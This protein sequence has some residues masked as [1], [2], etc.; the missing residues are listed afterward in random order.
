MLKN[1]L[2]ISFRNLKKSL[3]V[4]LINILGLAIGISCCL[5][6]VLYVSDELSYDKHWKNAD[7]I[8]RIT[9]HSNIGT[10]ETATARTPS[11]L[12]RTIVDEYPEILHATRL[13]HTP[14]MLVRYKD[15]VYNEDNF[16]WVDTNFF[17]V[18]PL[19][20]LYGDPKTA[21]K[22]DHTVVFTLDNAK[23]Y[24]RNPA[25]ALNKIVEFEDGTPYRVSAVVANPEEN[26]HFH[27]G[28][29]SPLSSWE[30]NWNEWWLWNF[31]C[32]YVLLHEEAD[33]QELEAKLPR[34]LQ[35]YAAPHFKETTGMT[36]DEMEK[37]G[38]KY[39]YKLQPITSIHLHSH[40]DGELEP[41]SD[42]KYIYIFS[43]TAVF[44]LFVAC[45][46]FMNLATSRSTGRARE[47]GMRKV[48]GS[49]KKR[50]IGQFLVESILTCIPAVI[51]AM[52]LSAILLPL[53]N[54]IANKEIV[55]N[56]LKP[57]YMLP[58]LGIFT[59]ILGVLA[60]SYPAFFLSSFQPVKVLKENLGLG[61]KGR[62][63][64]QIL[65]IFQ[66]TISIIL[67]ITTLLL[68]RQMHFIQNKRLGFNK[69]NIVVI[70]RGWALGQNPDG[71]F[72]DTTYQQSV[73][74]SF[75]NDLK[76]NPQIIS[77]CGT[78]N[79]PGE[80]LNNAVL[81]TKGSA[82]QEQHVIN[83]CRVDWDYAETFGIEMLEG[84]F[85]SREF[86]NWHGVI[87]NETAAKVFGLKQPYTEQYL[88]FP[89]DSSETIPIFGVVK[90]FHYE[91][92]HQPI[93]PLVIDFMTEGR[94]YIC[95]R[96]RPENVRETVNYIKP[97]WD[98]YIPYKPFEYFFFDDNYNNLYRAEIRTN[99]LFSIFS[100]LSI[101]IA[102]LGLFALAS[103]TT[104]RRIREIGIRK[105]LGATVPDILIL[106]TKEFA[107][108]VAIANLAAWPLA[109]YIM[110]RT[111]QSYAYRISIGP[112]PFLMAG[113]AALIIALITV[114]YH[115]IKAALSNPADTL[116]YE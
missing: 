100:I 75:K 49:T 44:I 89:G 93:K 19:K 79:L 91:S 74:E 17:D 110:R 28:M 36:F 67:F 47:V 81:T 109:Y 7:R 82:N 69:E 26:A 37:A 78:S 6:I 105:T 24:F 60:G 25:E 95:V 45:I 51:I 111:L 99:K 22:D 57:W 72:I 9:V 8:Y 85:Y 30:W 116:K 46:N 106:L 96:I 50:L 64:R 114:S 80:G 21:L 12:S 48:L 4:N 15:L 104:E 113:L 92:L 23:K 53:F 11:Q 41:N 84:R 101:I 94:T 34:F 83:H 27:Y 76:Q 88:G 55:I 5:L 31:M 73:F 52:I 63:F 58:V 66:F 71:S 38:G 98:K 115:S 107:L 16:L 29:L 3:G 13:E 56:Y 86:N 2:L 112:G 70:K 108:L 43:V 40:L 20:I 59:I 14:N 33:P 61:T 103:F 62:G 42:I 97:I 39:E 1:Y 68:I 35:K 65:V 54:T 10:E 32:T 18:F 87:I 102:S 90:D 77:V